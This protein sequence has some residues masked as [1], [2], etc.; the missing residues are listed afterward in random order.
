M[1]RLASRM[2]RAFTLIELLVVIAIIAILAAMLLPALAS[3]REK[4]RRT[5][6]AN[7]LNQMAKGLESYTSEYGGYFPAGHMWRL[8][9]TG[10][11][12]PRP[13][14]DGAWSYSYNGTPGPSDSDVNAMCE[15]YS[16]TGPNGTTETI[17]TKAQSDQGGCDKAEWFRC[18]ASGPPGPIYAS[19]PNLKLAPRGLGFLLAG[20]YLSEAKSFYCPSGQGVKVINTGSGMYGAGLDTWP[21]YYGPFQDLRDW[22]NAGGFGRNALHFGAWSNFQYWNGYQNY[23]NWRA[24][25]GQYNYRNMPIPIYMYT[26]GNADRVATIDEPTPVPFTK[27]VVTSNL[28]CPPFKTGKTLAGRALVSDSF[29]RM[30]DERSEHSGGINGT[31]AASARGYCG[32]GAYVHRD[33]YNVLYGD[34]H[35]A[36]FGDA[37]QRIIFWT[38]PTPAG[39]ASYG[40]WGLQSWAAIGAQFSHIGQAT[41]GR[42]WGTEADAVWHMLDNA[43]D[44]DMDTTAGPLPVGHYWQDL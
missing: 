34:G 17:A 13:Y 9:R 5:N 4:A 27:P 21:T 31:D 38:H 25:L 15:S 18:I 24:V 6:C 43:A 26:N 32:F 2:F 12:S 16:A 41:T 40:G 10:S 33:G 28:N 19:A 23:A 14:Y 22:A 3:A 44:V 1:A 20:D 42:Y 7:N 11:G 35:T 8:A 29:E 30:N 36:W 37:S 39:D